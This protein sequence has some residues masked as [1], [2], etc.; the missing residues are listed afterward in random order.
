MKAILSWGNEMRSGLFLGE[1]AGGHRC[2]E[3]QSEAGLYCKVLRICGAST[4]SGTP[5][6]LQC[7][8][9]KSRRERQLRAPGVNPAP[10]CPHPGSLLFSSLMESFWGTAPCFAT[11]HPKAG[12]G[13]LGRQ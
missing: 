9:T 2:T 6:C 3:L 12:G 8:Q 1:K 7:W 13:G 11:H 10:I 4:G 5:S